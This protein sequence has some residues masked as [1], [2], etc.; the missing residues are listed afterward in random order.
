MFGIPLHPLV[1]HFPIVLVVLLPISI[2]VALWAV[3]KGAT[4]RRVW[5]V[6]VALAATLTLSAWVATETGESQEDRVER[7]VARGAMHNHEES[8]ERFLVLSGA[9]AL[10]A[11]AGL[12]RGTVGRA[13]QLLTA[14]G[15]IGLVAAGAQVGHSG[16][17]LVYRHGAASAYTDPA[18][19]G[20]R[21]V[22][23]G[24]ASAVAQRDDDD[25]HHD[26]GQR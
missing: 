22:G 12:A 25:A 14:A 8:A 24:G 9:I 23:R 15:A 6:P 19:G 10:V 5:S 26:R 16:G 7:V 20:N 13:A 18:T 3:R 4:A 11:A 21:A 2:F 17:L 1:V